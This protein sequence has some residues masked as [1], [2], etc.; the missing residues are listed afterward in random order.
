MKIESFDLDN[1]RES[2]I[3]GSA[4]SVTSPVRLCSSDA[5]LVFLV[6]DWIWAYFVP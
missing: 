3:A 6:P 5:M 4:F 2:S 1:V